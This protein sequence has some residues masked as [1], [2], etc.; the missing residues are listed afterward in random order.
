M[1]RTRRK[2]TSRRNAGAKSK[3]LKNFTGVVRLNKDKT[4]S[5]VG[6][7][8]KANPGRKRSGGGYGVWTTPAGTVTVRKP[9]NKTK[10]EAERIAKGVR[11]SLRGGR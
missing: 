2:N 9:G 7:G 3:L 4:V 8:K 10:A 5:I 11:A 1:K 6:T